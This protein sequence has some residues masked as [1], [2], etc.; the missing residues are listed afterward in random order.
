LAYPKFRLDTQEQSELLA[1]YLPFTEVVGIPNPP[2]LIPDCRDPDDL[3][4]LVLAQAG[5]AQALVTGDADLLVLGRLDLCEVVTPEAFR[6][7]LG[8]RSL[9]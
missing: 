1:D 8:R 6:L 5:K 9:S 7:Q 3:P 2:P 4:F